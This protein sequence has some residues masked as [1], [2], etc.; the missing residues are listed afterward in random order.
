MSV[1]PSIAKLATPHSD[2]QLWDAVPKAAKL[3][4][5]RV[6]Y[7]VGSNDGNKLGIALGIADGLLLGLTLDWLGWS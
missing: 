5:G 7:N 3:N 6:G 4:T 2:V 1:L